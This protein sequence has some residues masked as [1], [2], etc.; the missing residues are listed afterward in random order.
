MSTTA[1]S[2]EPEGSD[3]AAG[4]EPPAH[5]KARRGVALV[6]GSVAITVIGAVL[7]ATKSPPHTDL[8]SLQWAGSAKAARQLAA[9]RLDD[10]RTAV[11]WDFALIAAY[12]IG[13]VLACYLGIRVFCT[14]APSR[15][16]IYGLVAAVVAGAFNVAQDVLL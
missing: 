7:F 9:A 12:T 15:W 16:S 3:D 4:P 6:I 2:A 11:R 10:Y 1:P 5:L 14:T 8:V 13:L